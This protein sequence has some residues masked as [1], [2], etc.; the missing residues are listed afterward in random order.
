MTTIFAI[1][2]C[3]NSHC[4]IVGNST[5]SSRE[6]CEQWIKDLRLDT[7][8]HSPKDSMGHMNYSCYGKAVSEWKPATTTPS[9]HD[10]SANDRAFND[11]VKRYQD[12]KS[13]KGE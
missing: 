6:Q 2:L 3:I 1:V 4:S 9:T 7:R 5:Y 12:E 10:E 8:D 13:N 11:A